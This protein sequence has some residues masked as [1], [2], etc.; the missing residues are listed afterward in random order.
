MTGKQGKWLLGACLAAAL[1]ANHGQG[2]LDPLPDWV[3]QFA[4]VKL[5]LRQNFERMPNYM[6]RENVERF[7]RASAHAR[8]V[9]SDS[10]QFE[11]AQ[12]DHKELLARPGIGGFEDRELSAYMSSGLLGNGQFSTLPMNLF[13]NGS[14]RITPHQERADQPAAGIAYDF[15]IPAF[16]NGLTIS[17]RGA[18]ASVGVRGTF[19]V[20]AESLDLIRIEEHAVDIPATVG[21]S[22]VTT[23]VQYGR[24]QIGVSSVV[25]PQ[26][27]EQMVTDLDGTERINKV[28]FST[29]R[30]YGS[31]STVTFG[32]RTEPVKKK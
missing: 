4:R 6:C 18:K 22:A 16:L 32:E 30:E 9:E 12:V 14:P 2:P 5:H 15:E 26:S 27:A 1:S 11:V 28:Q 25:L 7:E 19:W 31:E 10:L 13:V 24:M 8:L 17:A 20:D 23:T 29:C 21:M 3:K